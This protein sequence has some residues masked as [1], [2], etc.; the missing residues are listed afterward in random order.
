MDFI[1]GQY[2]TTTQWLN[3]M[4]NKGFNINDMVQQIYPE[5]KYLMKKGKTLKGME[6]LELRERYHYYKSAELTIIPNGKVIKSEGFVLTPD[7]KLLLDVCVDYNTISQEFYSAQLPSLQRT[8]ETLAVLTYRH[9]ENYF[10]WLFDVLPR[11]HLIQKSNIHVNRYIFNKLTQPFQYE[12]LAFFGIDRSQIIECDSNTHLQAE[13]LI[14]TPWIS[15]INYP[16]WSSDCVRA[17]FFENFK[18]NNNP[19]RL[20]GN[21]RLYFTRSDS[22]HRSVKNEI[23]VLRLLNS[24][25][26]KSVSLSTFTVREKVDLLSSAKVIITPFGAGETNFIFCQSDTKVIELYPSSYVNCHYQR[27]INYLNLDHYYLI[28][29]SEPE[30]DDIWEGSLDFQVNLRELTNLLNQYQILTL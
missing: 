20:V 11:I 10:H 25:G 5:G 23:S 27:Y 16:K 21:E 4:K 7:N 6:H 19:N 26:F 15:N 24:F 14:V 17:K 29:K 2:E 9:S 12:T 22:F 30:R 28:N 1:S 3:E 13:K 18:Y 8:N